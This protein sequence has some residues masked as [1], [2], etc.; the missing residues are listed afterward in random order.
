VLAQDVAD[1]EL[2][3][4]DDASTDGT[5]ALL[6]SITDPRLRVLRLDRNGGAAAARNAGIA[7]A[8]SEW[9]AFQDSDDEW[10][11][12]K[13]S[14]QLRVATPDVGLVL[15][16][17]EV[18]DQGLRLFVRPASTLDRGDAGPDMLA[19]WPIITPVWL[20]RRQLVAALDG[21]DLAYPVFEDWDLVFRISDACA[22]AAV[23]GPVLIKHGSADTLCANPKL[24]R[25]SL[26]LLLERHAQRWADHPW[27]LARRLTHLGCLRYQDG[28]I[29]AARATFLRA[30]RLRP[31]SP[32]PLL[33]LASY[34][35]RGV[36]RLQR[37][38]PHFAAMAP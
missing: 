5:T 35:G 14:A 10:L 24:V 2:L 1:F 15:G 31:L 30:A 29:D 20:V 28:Q 11:P 7:S 22:V 27:E 21:F 37:A 19:G 25:E 16:G 36:T 26:A 32:A 13:L 4:I 12:G 38:F 17:Y 9:L 3:V 18:D 6:A 34:A 23:E 33:L 8:R